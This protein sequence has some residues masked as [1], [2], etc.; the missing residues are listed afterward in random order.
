MTNV[1]AK[2]SFKHKTNS[3]LNYWEYE[4]IVDIFELTDF[5]PRLIR[6]MDDH[7]QNQNLRFVGLEMIGRLKVDA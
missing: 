7:R 2:L 6:E 1:S 3:P 4:Q 5:P